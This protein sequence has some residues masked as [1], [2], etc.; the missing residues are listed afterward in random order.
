MQNDATVTAADIARLAGVGR[1]A[2]SNWRRRHDDFPQPVGGTGS[3][4]SFS[5]QEIQG[6]LREQGKLES[7]PVEEQIW[8]DLRQVVDDA[9]L[10]DVM[11]FAGAF[12]LFLQRAPEAWAELAEQADEQVAGG[13]PGRIRIVAE[14]IVGDKAFPERLAVDSVPLARALAELAGGKGARETFEFL[15]TRYFELSSRRIYDTPRPVTDLMLRFAGPGVRTVLDPAC[16]SGG[17]LI[18]ALDHFDKVTGLLGQELDAPTSRLTALRLALRTESADIRA[19]DALR[20]DAFPGIQAD[21]VAGSPPFNDRNWGYEE[22]TA[23]PRWEY[24]LPPRMESELAWVQHALAHVGP[25]G[26]VVMLMPP[27]AANRKSGRRIRGQLLRRGALRAVIGLP[28]GAVPNMAVGLSLWILQKPGGS[29]RPPGQVLMV[30]AG[31]DDFADIAV[32]EWRRFERDPEGE[33]DE[34][35]VSKAVRIIDLLDDEIDLTPT[36]F[37]SQ[38]AEVPS[39]V[40]M[41]G[42]RGDLLS[43]LSAVTGLVP[44]IEA[45]AGPRPLISIAELARTG[46]LTVIS[47]HQLRA[48]GEAGEGPPVLTA[49]DVVSGNPPS[50]RLNDRNAGLP[51][52]EPGDVLVP[53]LV[54]TPV[55]HVDEQ[56]G[57][58]VGRHIHV[59]RPDPERIAPHFLAGILRGSRNL[60][61]YSS[62][63]TSYRVDV[64]RAEVPVLP[65]EEQRVYGETFRQLEGFRSALRRTVELSEEMARSITDGLADGSLRP[66]G[67]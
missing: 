45:G 24:G 15:R 37:V 30:D 40:E 13:L 7:A 52:T 47:A 51:L 19:G 58:V 20:D 16:G 1:A 10:S 39:A 14:R 32:R 11:V 33:L 29:A 61:H 48:Y 18:G 55:A 63:S 4:P 67:G 59:I 25:G 31:Q 26:T 56:G 66:S 28:L 50:A 34:P 49:Q 53:A 46:A 65:I 27:A 42:A 21:F 44:E 38:A 5:L 8:Q 57:A 43:L 12:L 64:R 22:L 54:R 41:I 62:I 3:S 36:R 9:R 60:R 17:L 35:G 2:V 6:W 23:D